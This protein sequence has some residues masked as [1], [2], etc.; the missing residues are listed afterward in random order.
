MTP[1]DAEGMFDVLTYEKGAAV[2]RMLEQFLGEEVFRDGVRHYLAEHLHGNTDNEDLWESLEAASGQPVRDL[3]HAWIFR[4]GHPLVEATT[5]DDG[6]VRLA[7]SPFRYDGEDDGTRWAVPVRLRTASGEHRL[8]LDPSRDATAVEAVADIADLRSLNV[9]ASGFYR[10][11]LLPTPGSPATE[12]AAAVADHWAQVLAGRVGHGSFLELADSLADDTDLGVWQA[13]LGGLTTLD[14]L[15]PGRFA[16]RAAT[17]LRPPI[18]RLGWE[19][20]PADDDRSRQLRG[21]V[22][23]AAGTVAAVDH[24]IAGARA[25]WDAPIVDPA[26]ATA[27]VAIVSAHGDADAYAECRERARRAETAQVEQRHLRALTRFPGSDEVSTLLD[28]LLGGGIRSQDAPYLLR[29]ALAHPWHRGF[30]WR[31]VTDRWDE[32]T[33]RFPSNSIARML[34]GVRSLVGADTDPDVEAFLQAQPVPQG[35]RQVAQ[36]LERRRVN[37]RLAER[38]APA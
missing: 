5:A 9:D 21:L 20:S 6:S 15:A 19:A 38:L 2:V 24:V 3:M 34:E 18:E 23:T 27:V 13:I 14:V 22:L 31:T 11:T 32:V 26:V 35:S 33:S 4:G 17:I 28:E 8:L 16:G 7:Q 10:T 36:H 25:L 29:D 30:V 1:E 12:R 37:Q